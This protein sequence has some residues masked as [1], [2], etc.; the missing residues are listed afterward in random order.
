MCGILG[1]FAFDGRLR[2]VDPLRRLVSTLAHRGP[3]GSAWCADGPYFFS[4]RR[5]AIIDLAQGAASSH[6]RGA[7]SSRS[8][9]R[10]HNYR[11]RQGSVARH[12]FRT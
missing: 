8:T 5:L 2:S 12:V 11:A 10:S 6:Q 4:H 1:Q 3:D 7:P 9:A